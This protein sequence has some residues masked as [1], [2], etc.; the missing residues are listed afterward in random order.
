MLGT[1]K[2]L[3]SAYIIVLIFRVLMAYDLLIYGGNEVS[4][5]TVCTRYAGKAESNT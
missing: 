5:N 1:N 4:T 3:I 2:Y